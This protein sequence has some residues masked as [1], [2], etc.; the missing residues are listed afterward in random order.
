[1]DAFP[2]FESNSL[3]KMSLQVPTL[4]GNNFSLRMVLTDCD[5][6]VPQH[7]H[8]ILAKPCPILL[9]QIGTHDTRILINIPNPLPKVGNGDMDKYLRTNI[10][11]QLPKSIQPSF[12]SALD[13]ERIRSMPCSWLPPSQNT[14]EGVFVV[15]DA[16]NMRHPLTGGG[17][18]V[19]FWDIIALRDCLRENPDLTQSAQVTR[20]LLMDHHWKRKNVS[21]VVNILA[22][23][24]YELFSANDS[25]IRLILDPWAIELQN[26]CFSYF[27]LGGACVDT[28]VGLLAAV[29][30]EPMTLIGH[31]FA[32]AMYGM[33][34]LWSGPIYLL[35]WN[36][37]KSFIV[38]WKATMIIGPLILAELRV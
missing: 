19:A 3:P 5:M 22:N 4:Q 26:A 15:G 1:M 25:I 38:M 9:Y 11:P 24:L 8:V 32:V 31:F 29:R 10:G 21:S 23:A 34:L 37:I 2:H 18:S 20:K 35:P 36:I 13:T 27:Q 17:M 7:G 6:P 12:Y 14:A 33:L 16:Q 30:P 28:P